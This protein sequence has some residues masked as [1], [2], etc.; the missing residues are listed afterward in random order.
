MVAA[1]VVSAPGATGA[2]AS[3]SAA[4]APARADGGTFPCRGGSRHTVVDQALRPLELS[5]DD[6][7]IARLGRVPQ[8]LPRMGQPQQ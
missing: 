3:G 5:F 4:R 2:S 6:T 7:T 1:A 8:I